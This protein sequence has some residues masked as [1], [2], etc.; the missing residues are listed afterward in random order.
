[1]TRIE[2]VG[3]GFV[4]FNESDKTTIIDIYFASCN[5]NFGQFIRNRFI[6]KNTRIV[7]VVN[8]YSILIGCLHDDTDADE[9]TG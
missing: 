3:F 8:D 9:L 5:L 6:L 7:V 1:M 2:K 4:S